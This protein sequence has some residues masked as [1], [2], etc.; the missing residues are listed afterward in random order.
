MKEGVWVETTPNGAKTWLGTE[1]CD[2]Y[3]RISGIKIFRWHVMLVNTTSKKACYR[4]EAFRYNFDDVLVRKFPVSYN[5]YEL[6]AEKLD[7]EI[8]KEAPVSSSP[9]EMY[10]NFLDH[11]RTDFY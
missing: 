9:P 7:D 11:P 3:Y 2:S 8:A 5:I 4:D 6:S 1:G 10:A